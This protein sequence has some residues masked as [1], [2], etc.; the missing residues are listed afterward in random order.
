VAQITDDAGTLRLVLALPSWDDYLQ[1]A[2]DD[3][4]ESSSR[5]P[6]ALLRARAMLSSLLTAAPPQR[7]P[8]ITWR[9]RR[10]EELAAGNF[11]GLWRNM[12]GGD[13]DKPD[14][15]R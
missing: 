10:T 11:P 5:S 8:S 1:I 13:P 14:Q 9:L 2:L 12:T 3:L 4:I 15:S 7:K 6:M